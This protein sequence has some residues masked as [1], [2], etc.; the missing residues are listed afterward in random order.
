[1]VP[2][3]PPPRRG[4]SA[5]W[6]RSLRSLRAATRRRETCR[7][8]AL[9]VRRIRAAHIGAFGPLEA[10][11]AK[12]FDG[13]GGVFGPAAGAV[14][15]FDA[16]HESRPAGPFGGEGERPRVAYVEMAGRRRCDTSAKWHGQQGLEYLRNQTRK[17]QA[18]ARGSGE[19]REVNDQSVG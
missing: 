11:P 18:Q 1:M 16:K 19:H 8:F 9:H 15:I 10:E 7:P 6:G 3:P 4:A 13:G 5:G 17:T 14:E 2:S 12:V